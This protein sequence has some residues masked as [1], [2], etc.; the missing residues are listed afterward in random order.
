[1]IEVTEND[2][3]AAERFKLFQLTAFYF[4]LGR[5]NFGGFSLGVNQQGK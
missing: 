1:V 3:S 4:H 2:S 5:N